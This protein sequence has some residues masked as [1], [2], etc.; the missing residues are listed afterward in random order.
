M[1]GGE[2]Q[3]RYVMVSGGGCRN[4][5]GIVC[6][7][8]VVCPTTTTDLFHSTHVGHT[9]SPQWSRADDTVARGSHSMLSGES[10]VG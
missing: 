9:R 8:L 4:Q 5:Q 2:L 6:E 1:G 7:L 10:L 3:C